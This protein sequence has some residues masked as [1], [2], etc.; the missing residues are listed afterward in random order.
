[1]DRRPICAGFGGLGDVSALELADI[2]TGRGN[3]P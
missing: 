3:R 1:M 2:V